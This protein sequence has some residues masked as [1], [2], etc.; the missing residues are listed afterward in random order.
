MRRWI[1]VAGW[2]CAA[3][4]AAVVLAYH[5]ALAW[6]WP[7]NFDEAYNLQ[8]PLN[9]VL[10]GRYQTW[11]DE[12]LLFPHQIT[13]GPTVLLPIAAA[14]ALAGP[15]HYAARAVMT[16]FLLGFLW[17]G[18]ALCRRL[19]GR[20]GNWAFAGAAALF[21]LVPLA[22]WLSSIVL[23]ELPG[24]FAFL[25]GVT[26]LQRAL[27]RDR[28]GLAVA[29]GLA[30]GLALLCK[31]V[32]LMCTA[33]A[34]LALLLC[35]ELRGRRR[36]VLGFG[37]L[38]GVGLVLPPA[39]WEGLKALVL[40]REDYLRHVDRFWSLMAFGGSGISREGGLKAAP[41]VGAHF[42]VL[43]RELG[44]PS[45]APAAGLGLAAAV[46]LWT[47]ARGPRSYAL[48]GLVLAGVVYW[49]W[50]LRLSTWLIVRHL[51]VGYVVYALVLPLVAAAVAM[52]RRLRW[53]VRA[54]LLAAL[55]AFTLPPWRPLPTPW[56]QRMDLVEQQRAAEWVRLIRRLNANNRFWSYGW[57]QAPEISFLAQT[58]FRDI[59]RHTPPAD[60]PNF[61]VLTGFYIGTVM[62]LDYARRYCDQVIT[63]GRNV[64]LCRLRPG[65]PRARETT[66]RP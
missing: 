36:A 64:R 18:H 46:T 37:A 38:A 41:S 24:V 15:S 33:G 14:F 26:L 50:W 23:G 7:L 29:A 47:L 5:L 59:T 9:L 1:D 57:M 4:A 25:T 54:L 48:L 8:V 32:L 58:P 51:V 39:A 27:D 3:I 52:D 34:L 43:A 62:H 53:E 42:D 6:M 55:A 63:A 17:Q 30:F 28:A 31:L 60:E 21:V 22:P 56:S 44:E 66:H 13:T 40:G 65:A 35:Q 19:A 16:L 49:A 20:G 61:L 2:A 11:Y 45:W 12:P 10:N